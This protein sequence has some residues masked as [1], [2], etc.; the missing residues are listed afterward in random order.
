[1]AAKILL[2]LR[3]IFIVFIHIVLF[4]SIALAISGLSSS[5]SSSLSLPEEYSILK[6]N[7]DVYRDKY[8]PAPSSAPSSAPNPPVTSCEMDLDGIGSF[9]TLCQMRSSL[10]LTEDIHILGSGSFEILDDVEL[11]CPLAG[12]SLVFNLS[13]EIRMR[14]G[15]AIVAGSIYIE[16]LN[17]SVAETAVVNASAL[18][19]DPPED[20]SGVPLGTFGDGGGY[21]GRGASCYNEQDKLQGDSWGG[22]AYGWLSL[23]YP[24]MY[25]S[26]G[27]TTS[28]E[29]DYGGGGGG[30]VR[31]LAG[32]MLEFGGTILAD[33]GDAGELGGGGSG[34]S[35]FLTANKM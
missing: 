14:N 5:L 23:M 16:A 21:G 35:I 10:E 6:D 9:D 22:D 2:P 20:S 28:R 32:D 26:K 17:V 33:G 3:S 29:V 30:K 11:S 13:G 8:V 25:G 34:G 12:C 27:G 31:I 1:M 15:S 24:D 18:G 19:G 4:D 7:H